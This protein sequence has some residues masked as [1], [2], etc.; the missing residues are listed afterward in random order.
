[1]PEVGLVAAALPLQGQQEVPPAPDAA[2]LVL[3]D[4]VDEQERQHPDVPLR[5]LGPDDVEHAVQGVQAV[6]V[7]HLLLGPRFEAA[8]SPGR[9]RVAARGRNVPV[10]HIPAG[11]GRCRPGAA[12]PARQPSVVQGPGR[13]AARAGVQR[14]GLDVR[15]RLLGRGVG[16]DVGGNNSTGEMGLLRGH[17]RAS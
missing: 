4:D 10:R 15:P 2:A 12:R 9:V 3:V 7:V 11:P 5:Q 17:L 16:G 1:M 13:R 14:V 6:G 8:V